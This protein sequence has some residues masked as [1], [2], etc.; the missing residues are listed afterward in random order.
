[1]QYR[2][3]NTR[4]G[5]IGGLGLALAMT[6]AMAWGCKGKAIHQS[7]GVDAGEPKSVP[8]FALENSGYSFGNVV[9]GDSLSHSFVIKNQGSKPLIITDVVES[10]SCTLAKLADRQIAPG[11]STVLEV[12]YRPNGI[13]GPDRQIL[14]LRTNDP[15]NSEVIITIAANVE[16]D[17][18]FDP[19]I[20]RL[21]SD[22]PKRRS[23][24][25]E[26]V[27][28]VVSRARLS[29]AE[30]RGD[31]AALKN[32]SVKVT[33]APYDLDNKPAVKVSLKG[34][35]PGSGSGVAVVV[36]NIP[37]AFQLYVRFEWGPSAK[38]AESSKQ[39]TR[40]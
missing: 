38:F 16:A 6:C 3:V 18:K 9:Q 37:D 22:D 21:I 34:K 36:T 1:M 17:L 10:C 19:D 5:E 30:L 14:T 20:I 24:S 33:E 7:F 12:R 25:S 13:T 40:H 29:V 11:S 28:R 15:E 8:R 35:N 32:V 23:Q 39:P 26:L 27:G 31:P 4:I 2:K